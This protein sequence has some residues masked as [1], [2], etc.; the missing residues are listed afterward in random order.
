MCPAQVASRHLLEDTPIQGITQQA[1]VRA[2][3]DQVE[4][5]VGRPSCTGHI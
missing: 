2:E 1:L 4:S 5:L 3:W